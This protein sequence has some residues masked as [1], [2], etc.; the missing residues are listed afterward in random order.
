M[1]A[2]AKSA[3]KGVTNAILAKAGSIPAGSELWPVI[4]RMG[5]FRRD[6]AYE[7][8]DAV[9]HVVRSTNTQIVWQS[10]M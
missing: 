5:F 2:A 3:Q 4:N 7:T 10:Q 8:L 1:T 6:N 9:I